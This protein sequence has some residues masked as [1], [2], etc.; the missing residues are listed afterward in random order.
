MRTIGRRAVSA[1]LGLAATAPLLARPARA[2]L[3]TL[4]A[5]ARKQGAITWYI[6]QIDGESAEAVGRAFT[7]RYPGIA[8]TVMRTTGQV[9]Y[10]RL[11]QDLKNGA[12][13]CDVFS[14]T[15]ISHYP[16]LIRKQALA[17]YTPQN[18]AAIAPAFDGLGEPGLYYPT[19]ATLYLQLY[20]TKNVAAAD[21]PK[22]WTDLLDPKW[23]GK[24]ALGHPAFSGY[25]GVWVTAM[26]KMY[27]WKFFESLEKNKPLIGRSSL[28]PITNINAGERQIGCGP[29]SG[30]LLSAGKGN[31]IAVQYPTDG[32]VL[33]IGPAAVMANAPHPDA[34]R[35]FMEWLLSAEF[36][37]ICV[38]IGCDPVRADVAPPAGAKPLSEVK[39]IRLNTAEIGR[40]VPEAIENWRDTFGT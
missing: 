3:A 38:S 18:A 30:G 10:E 25:A 13:Q 9:A 32:A 21:A 12:P 26:T 27:G 15:D 37:K 20:S 7:A 22:S 6:A 29:L 31:P 4:E 23:K 11:Q 24:I 19:T 14:S 34:A 33:C 40:G 17:H 1:G 35:L 5:A 8:V 39:L 2:E 16:A 28:D 36:A